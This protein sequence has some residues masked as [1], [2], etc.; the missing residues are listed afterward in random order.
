MKWIE[1]EECWVNLELV[2]TVEFDLVA[3]ESAW[4]GRWKFTY[5]D[6][7]SE[8]LELSDAQGVRLSEILGE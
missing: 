4:G 3:H 7:G 8:T 5:Q 6:G 2:R 1:T